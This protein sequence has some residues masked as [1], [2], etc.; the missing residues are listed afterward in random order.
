VSKFEQEKT[1]KKRSLFWGQLRGK[2]HA[3]IEEHYDELMQKK[4]EQ[5]EK[6]KE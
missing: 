3:K 5:Q 4:Q 6:K 1:K 2:V